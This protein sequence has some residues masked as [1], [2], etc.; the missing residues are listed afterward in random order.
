VTLYLRQKC[1]FF[2]KMLH[3]Q[4]M[5]M[6]TLEDIRKDRTLVNSIDWAMT[7]EEAVTLYLEWGNNTAHGRKMVKSKK[8]VSYYFVVNT[9]DEPPKIYLVRRNSD[10]AVDLAAIELPPHLRKRFAE[11]VARRKSVYGLTPEVKEWLQK[12]TGQEA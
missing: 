2:L 6:M 8:D 5:I 4:G 1:L 10:E 9:W 7:P 11:T 3:Y 12:E